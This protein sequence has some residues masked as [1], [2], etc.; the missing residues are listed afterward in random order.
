MSLPP[1]PYVH[2]SHPDNFNLGKQGR[3]S[4]WQSRYVYT[5]KR[6]TVRFFWLVIK[7]K[8]FIL[9]NRIALTA[10]KVYPHPVE[11]SQESTPH[12]ARSQRIHQEVLTTFKDLLMTTSR[13]KDTPENQAHFLMR[14]SPHKMIFIRMGILEVPTL[15]RT[16]KS[17]E[18]A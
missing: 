8:I 1:A 16:K 4:S 15:S 5:L 13:E 2:D 17:M 18:P 10:E 3:G 7:V 14:D 6:F 11:T 9:G 12:G